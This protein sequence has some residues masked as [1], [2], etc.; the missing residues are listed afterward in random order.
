MNNNQ[1]T[2]NVT[3][4]A[5]QI[6]DLKDTLTA[7][8]ISVL[9]L[10]LV[11]CVNYKPPVSN[12]KGVTDENCGYLSNCNGPCNK[13]GKI[14]DGMTFKKK[15]KTKM[16]EYSCSIIPVDETPYSPANLPLTNTAQ[17]SATAAT[18]SEGLDKPQEE[19]ATQVIL[20]YRIYEDVCF[21]VERILKETSA[22][23][24]DASKPYLDQSVM[25]ISMADFTSVILDL[26]RIFDIE[27]SNIETIVD[28]FG[29]TPP[30]ISREESTTLH[31]FVEVVCKKLDIPI[32]EKKSKK[33]KA[34]PI[35]QKGPFS[36]GRMFVSE[37]IFPP[38][39]VKVRGE[40]GYEYTG[41]TSYL[42]NADYSVDLIS[43]SNSKELLENN[44]SRASSTLGRHIY[45]SRLLFIN[46]TN[47]QK[48]EM[49]FSDNGCNL[50]LFQERTHEYDYALIGRR[51]FG[52]LSK[53][54]I[55]IDFDLA[56]KM[57]TATLKVKL[58]TTTNPLIRV[59]GFKLGYY[60]EC[61][62]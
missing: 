32:P 47:G 40:N 35:L 3:S 49:F 31:K 20:D 16:G 30:D 17:E 42:N 15:L 46:I 7:D 13:C 10:T 19:I 27:I 36:N 23:S 58:I 9:I 28:G 18:P 44:P 26:E 1:H 52:T 38:V 48:S 51:I 61:T 33:N 45:I 53:P 43:I 21:D 55:I 24:L 34:I 60:T 2:P 54:D 4:L 37:N 5:K 12:C 11:T 59:L 62:I 14:H 29:F 25:S 8:D 57:D 39:E 50:T 56:I 6:N 41:L 22:D